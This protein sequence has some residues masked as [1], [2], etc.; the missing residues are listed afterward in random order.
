MRGAKLAPKIRVLVGA[1]VA[2][3]PGRANL[4]ESIAR[5]GS[6]SAAA[7]EMG[8]SYRRAWLLVAALNGCFRKPLVE[9]AIGGQGGGGA[10]L[11]AQG[12]EVLRLY[13]SMEVKAARS[14]RPELARL[15]RELRRG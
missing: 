10:R 11:T 6:I 4:L 12:A 14:V 15:A 7:R 8:M 2:V 1:V 9:R 5:T 3:G 13:R